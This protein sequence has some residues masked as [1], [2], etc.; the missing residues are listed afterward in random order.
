M[1]FDETTQ[2]W[3]HATPVVRE[4]VES[5]YLLAAYQA[6]LAQIGTSL[7]ELRAVRGADEEARTALAQ[8]LGIVLRPDATK[9]ETLTRLLLAPGDIS[10]SVLEELFGL[11]DTTRDGLSEGQVRGDG[12]GQIRRFELDGV[13]WSSNPWIANVGREGDLRLAL[14]KLPNQK[15]QVDVVRHDGR[16]VASGTGGASGRLRLT[17][18]S[19]SHLSGSL[20]LKYVQ[21]TSSIELGVVP[22]VT[23]WRLER[24]REIWDGQD[25]PSSQ[26]EA[27]LDADR[28]AAARH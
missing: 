18:A 1:R 17:E 10:E 7:E 11:V 23:A 12:R 26:F 9:P 6:L 13:T 15:I 8:R 14:A 5:E 2:T 19:Q 4:D 22:R 25:W 16:N 27:Q 20:E 21:D 24:L 3:R 28:T